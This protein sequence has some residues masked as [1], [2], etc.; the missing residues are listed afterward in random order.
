MNNSNNLNRL[1]VY[2]LNNNKIIT[3]LHTAYICSF[4]IIKYYSNFCIFTTC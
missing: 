1:T 3:K 2:N 4:G